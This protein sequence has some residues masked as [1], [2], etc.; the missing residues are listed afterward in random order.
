MS[1]FHGLMMNLPLSE[2]AK[3]ALNDGGLER[4][5]TLGFR[6]AR[7]AAAEAALEADSHLEGSCELLKDVQKFLTSDDVSDEARVALLGRIEYAIQSLSSI[8]SGH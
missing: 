5:Y 1:H 2:K 6:D 7:H 3:A 8:T 4:D